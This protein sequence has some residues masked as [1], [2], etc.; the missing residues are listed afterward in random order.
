MSRST[1]GSSG[2]SV[3]QPTRLNTANSMTSNVDLR[4][5]GRLSDD[6]LRCPFARNLGPS[7]A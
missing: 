6:S 4:M 7:R 3:V 2:V 5:I 1:R